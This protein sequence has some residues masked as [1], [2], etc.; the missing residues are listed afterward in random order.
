MLKS[1]LC[2]YSDPYILISGTITIDG[3]GADYNA[4]RIDKINKG[5]IFNNCAPFTGCISEINNIQIDNAKD[6]DVVMPMYDLI[7]CISN[8]SETS[9]SLCQYY[10]DDPHY[11]IVET[12]S[13]K[14]KINIIGC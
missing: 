5:V 2:D 14:L 12:E 10:R 6:L 1:S 4:K 8:Y 11:N 7:E 3:A 13:F 9:G